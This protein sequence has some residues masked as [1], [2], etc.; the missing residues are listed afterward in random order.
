[1]DLAL[2]AKVAYNSGSLLAPGYVRLIELLKMHTTL[3]LTC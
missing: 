1:M 2:G 3:S